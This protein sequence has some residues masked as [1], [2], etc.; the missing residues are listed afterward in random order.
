MKI[1]RY[2]CL[3]AA[4]CG[5]AAAANADPIDFH[6]N[7]L[8]PAFFRTNVPSQPFVVTF[9][10]CNG[11]LPSGVSPA[12]TGCFFGRN[13]SGVTWTGLQLLFPVSGAIANQT[14]NCAPQPSGNIFT[15]FNCG[16]INNNSQ[17]LLSFA[18]GL[19]PNNSEFVITESGVADPTLFPNGTLDFSVPEPTSILLLSTGSLLMGLLVVKQR[20]SASRLFGL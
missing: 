18:G 7:I 13:T 17:F 20:K 12:P 4:F 11:P 19:I 14:A 8:D 3:A 5:V 9:G 2:L 1:F 6:A 15:S 10:N 16:F